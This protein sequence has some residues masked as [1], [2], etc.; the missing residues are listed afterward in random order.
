M[1]LNFDEFKLE[2][3]HKRHGVTTWNLEL[4]KDKTV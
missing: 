4:G 1:W 3:L 2:G